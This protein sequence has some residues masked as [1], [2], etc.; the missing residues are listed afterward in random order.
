VYDLINQIYH[1][2]CFPFMRQLSD[3]SVHLILTD[4]PYGI[5]YQNNFTSEKLPYLIG[6]TGIDYPEFAKQ[7]YRILQNNSHAYFFTRFDKYPYHYECLVNAG[8]TIKNCLVI[9]KGQGGN[10]GDLY[11]SY[12]NNCEWVIFCHKGRRIFSQTKLLRN[13]KFGMKSDSHNRNPTLEYKTRFYCCWFGEDYPK[14]TYNSSWRIKQ[15]YKHP[16]IKNI[17]CLEWLI[18]I[19]SNQEDIVFDPFMGSGSTAI[20]AANT[21]RYY[22]GTEIDNS[23]YQLSLQ[24]IEAESLQKIKHIRKGD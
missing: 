11:G 17:R 22:L 14:S 23:H 20:A 21:G 16:T 3:E 15:N 7:C 19:S 2:D 4:P 24:R 1:T 13:K 9:E 8:F 10:N 18:Q 5:Q 6:D 12:A